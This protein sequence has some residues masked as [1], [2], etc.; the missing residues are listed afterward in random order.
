MEIQGD[1]DIFFEMC[2]ADCRE[3]LD[4]QGPIDNGLTVDEMLHEFS[5]DPDYH[6]FLDMVQAQAQAEEK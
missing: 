2:G 5:L 4:D 1:A 6:G 3:F